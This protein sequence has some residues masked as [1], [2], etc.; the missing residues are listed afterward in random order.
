MGRV[1][2]LPIDMDTGSHSY[3]MAGRHAKPGSTIGN[4]GGDS[5]IRKIWREV[6][7]IQRYGICI[8]HWEEIN[9]S[10]IAPSATPSSAALVSS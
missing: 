10:S 6:D 7:S 1:Y 4:C 2:Y 8:S 5:Y 9:T 3:S